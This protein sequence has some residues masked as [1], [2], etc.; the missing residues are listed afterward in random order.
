[1]ARREF[2]GIF[3]A[4]F[5][6]ARRNRTDDILLAKQALSLLSYGPE[7]VHKDGIE[8]P[9]R[10]PSTRRSTSEL[11]VRNGAAGGKSNPSSPRWQRGALPLSYGRECGGRNLV[12]KTWWAGMDS[13]HLRMN[14]A[15]TER[16]AHQC[17]ACPKLV[18]GAQNCLQG[19]SR[20]RLEQLMR[21]P[22]SRTSL[23][24]SCE[25]L[26]ESRRVDRHGFTPLT[27]FERGS[28]AALIDSPW[29]KAVVLIHNACASDP[30][31]TDAGLPAG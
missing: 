18:A 5:G 14:G 31:P 28:G 16:W 8:P 25:K 10:A 19:G 29:R 3:V 20:I 7:M 23:R 12:G 17:P 11:L 2:F 4:Q 1:M 22:G 6:G 27:R 13:N 26:A 30:L 21:L 9:T 24:E 15:F